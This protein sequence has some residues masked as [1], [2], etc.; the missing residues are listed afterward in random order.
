MNEQL[1]V[2]FRVLCEMMIDRGITPN[3][4]DNKSAAE[5]IEIARDRNIF[6]IQVNEDIKVLYILGKVQAS[7]IRALIDKDVDKLVIFIYDSKINP[8]TLNKIAVEGVR[9]QQFDMLR[10]LFNPYRHELVPPHI[11]ITD[12]EIIDKITKSFY[13][14]APSYF[15]ILNSA[16]PI[17]QYLDIRPHTLVEIRRASPTSGEHKIYRYCL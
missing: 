4:L 2:S 16:D 11:P 3:Y 9:I 13:I 5:I 8:Q 14:P 15:P 10:M 1:A 6:T 17:A 7:D 12:K